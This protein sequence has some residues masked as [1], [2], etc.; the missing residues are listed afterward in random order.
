MPRTGR[1]ANDLSGKKFGRLTVV[2]RAENAK[3]GHAQWNCICDCGNETTV[4]GSMLKSGATKS[5]GCLA[6]EK[7]TKHGLRYDRLYAIWKGMK[8]RCNNPKYRDYKWYGGKGIKLCPEWNDS[9]EAFHDWAYANGYDPRAPRGKCT[10]DRIDPNGDYEPSNCRFADM[11]TQR[12]NQS[13]MKDAA[14]VTCK[15]GEE[16]EAF[17]RIRTC[18][19]CGRRL[20]A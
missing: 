16:I 8:S 4:I 3:D 14:F 10:I 12:V 13:R 1:P 15:C 19:S 9:F 5:C 6:K 7:V 18:P 2:S 17:G 20:M 11:H